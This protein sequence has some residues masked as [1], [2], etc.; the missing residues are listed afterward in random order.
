MLSVYCVI[1]FLQ[2]LLEIFVAPRNICRVPLDMRPG[3]RVCLNAMRLLYL[4]GFDQYLSGPTKCS[5]FPKYH[6]SGKKRTFS[7]PRVA[8][9]GHTDRHSEMNKNVFV[10]IRCKI[11]DISET[12]YAFMGD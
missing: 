6:N 1:S 12:N 10:N 2:L 9:C 5:K 8:T 3:T 11:F 7:F 4:S